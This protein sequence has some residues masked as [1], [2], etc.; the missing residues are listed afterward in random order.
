[1]LADYREST[2]HFIYVDHKKIYLERSGMTET[3]N[4]GEGEEQKDL[5]DQWEESILKNDKIDIINLRIQA[6]QYLKLGNDIFNAKYELKESYLMINQTNLTDP[7][8]IPNEFVHDMFEIQAIQ[9]NA[10]LE[11][12]TE[13]IEVDL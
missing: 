9:S 2:Q 6:K 7:N 13:T 4:G 8:K 5:F 1:M 11:S 10:F 3:K 12:V